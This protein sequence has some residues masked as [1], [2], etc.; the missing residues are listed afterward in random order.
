MTEKT[1]KRKSGTMDSSSNPPA[2]T[3]DEQ[4]E[5][6]SEERIEALRN[7]EQIF[8]YHFKDISLL[9]NALTHRSFVHE[10][11]TL[12]CKDNER[13]E[14][15]GDA[16]LELCVSDLL[17]KRFPD[18][19]EG[20]LS[21]L[22][23][24]LVNEQ[25]LADLA[26]RFKVGDYLLL[27]K[28]E[29]SS[30]GRVKNSILANTSEAV[31]AAVYLDCGLEKTEEFIEN[32]LDSLIEKGEKILFYRDYKTA[33]QEISQTRFKEIPQYILLGEYGPEHNKVFEVGVYIANVITACGTGK[34]KKEAEQDAAKKVYEELQKTRV[35]SLQEAS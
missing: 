18:Y 31:I 33:I 26:R 23:A 7:F 9:N 21:K 2:T 30:G 20:Q 12:A 6:L 14:F 3:G 32:L 8:S 16:V 34:S 10:N 4:R 13:L 25:P 15:L 17:M 11:Q 27:G 5:G 28:G 35:E 1:Y 24:S 22:R 29:E 19:T